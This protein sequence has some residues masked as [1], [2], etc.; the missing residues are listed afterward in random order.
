MIRYIARRILTLIPTVLIVV[1]IIFS[2]VHFM[3]SSPGRIILGMLATDEEVNALNEEMG[4]NDPLPV[5]YVHYLGDALR[6]DFGTSYQSGR[7]VFEVLLPK[8]PTTLVLAVLSMLAASLIGI[9]LG[10]LSAVKQYSAADTVTTV[11]ALFF[12]SIPSFFLGMV[13][14][15]IF[16]VRLGWLPSNGIGTWKHYV[17]PVLTLALP[18]AA[19]LSRLTRTTMLDVLGQDF[20]TT[21]RAKG[22][23]W[24]RIIFAHALRNAMIPVVTQIGMSFALL[25]GGSIIVEQVFGLPGFGSALLTAITYKDSPLIV[26]ATVFL[27]VLFILIM[28]AV[29]LIYALLD[30]RIAARNYG[31]KD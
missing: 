7:P 31:G 5:Q 21:A 25:L 18:V 1:F 6:G 15:L 14:M 24:R 29:D 23:P 10:I 4:Y 13:L 20:V 19:Y 30:P 12:A 11:S 26:G 27:S 22:C 3:P 28:L 8:F 16:S 9:P 17:L 2:I